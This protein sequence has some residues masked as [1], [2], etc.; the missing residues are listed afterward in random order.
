[1]LRCAAQPHVHHRLSAGCATQTSGGLIQAIFPG[2]CTLFLGDA[3]IPHPLAR[4]NDT[5][6]RKADCDAEATAAIT[7][8]RDKCGRAS[9]LGA[10]ALTPVLLKMF[11][12]IRQLTS[13]RVLH[14]LLA[15]SRLLRVPAFAPTQ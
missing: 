9:A 4:F 5:A 10:S 1:M 11:E 6:A 7:M 3:C 14:S 13:G 12:R 8:K 15:L 2:A